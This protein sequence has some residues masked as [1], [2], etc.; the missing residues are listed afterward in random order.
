MSRI[1][2]LNFLMSISIPKTPSNLPF[3]MTGAVKVITRSFVEVT[4]GSV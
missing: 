1:L 4:L 3:F 2:S